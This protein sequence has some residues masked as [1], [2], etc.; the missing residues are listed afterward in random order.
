LFILTAY[1]WLR[2]SLVPI[3][4]LI[5]IATGLPAVGS[6]IAFLPHS[7]ATRA[8]VIDSQPSTDA[9]GNVSYC[10][11]LAYTTTAGRSMQGV[12]G[13]D[14]Q[15]SPFGVG[16]IMMIRYRPDQPTTLRID[17]FFGM[18]G[19]IIWSIGVGILLEALAL[20][21]LF[22]RFN[23]PIRAFVDEVRQRRAQRFQ[24]G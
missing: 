18:W 21:V 14:C 7:V 24:E 15:S 13:Q 8:H 20:G 23:A 11:V 6:T 5:L 22:W 10:P 19:S 4:G 17:D 2:F 12:G 16:Q 1:R 3:A 9:K